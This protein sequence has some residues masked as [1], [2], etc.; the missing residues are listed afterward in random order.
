MLQQTQVATVL[1]Y[2]ERWL[3]Q[4]PT[5][6]SL[7]EAD[8]ASA[9]AAWQ[10]L[11]YYRRCKLLIEGSKWVAEYGYPRT[12]EGWREIPGV[13]EYTASAVA[14]IAF[15]D[16]SALVDGNV[17][18]VFA[19]VTANSKTGRPLHKEAL[20]WAEKRLVR[21]KPGDWNQALMELG[22]TVCTPKNPQC[23]KCP[24]E[25]WCVARQTWKVEEF[26]AKK[27]RPDTV[28]LHQLTW[29]PY[30][31]GKF[32]IRQIESGTWWRG[33]WEFPRVEVEHHSELESEE[34]RNLLPDGWVEDL[35]MQQ[36][37]VTH[38][39]IY[40]RAC[41]IRC[42]EQVKGLKWVDAKELARIALPSPQRKVLSAALLHIG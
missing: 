20:A 24:I 42:S 35:G 8:E 16:P 23:K 32:G 5:P 39:R 36:C 27:Q 17:E 6:Q 38:H 26:P 40:L 3:N 21:D 19:R 29:V 31:D 41:L 14:S 7:A 9:L 11:G 34:L 2:Y 1:P 30:C 15:S 25:V 28:V 33:M 22:A 10:G 4:F 12:A 13:G 18:R 37:H